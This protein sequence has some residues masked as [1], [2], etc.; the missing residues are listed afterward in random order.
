MKRLKRCRLGGWPAWLPVSVGLLGH[1][2]TRTQLSAFTCT[3]RTSTP[4]GYSSVTSAFLLHPSSSFSS[5]STPA[6]LQPPSSL[7]ITLW[8]QVPTFRQQL[9]AAFHKTVVQTA[10]SDVAPCLEGLSV[11]HTSS[12]YLEYSLLWNNLQKILAAT[13][14]SFLMFS[15][16][17]ISAYLC[18]LPFTCP[19][20]SLHF[21]L[22]FFLIL[23][24][25]SIPALFTVTEI[26]NTSKELLL[27]WRARTK[28]STALAK[29]VYVRKAAAMCKRGFFF[30]SQGFPHVT[31][32]A[33]LPHLLP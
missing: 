12:F 1:D 21:W 16:V 28:D 23:V 20:N 10:T 3:P 30:W 7:L 5:H 9:G 2:T 29:M 11:S 6:P 26:I 17:P 14:K 22:V 19:V 24:H 31:V 27:S 18:F 8:V 32:L 25:N 4:S 33:L 15:C 13:M